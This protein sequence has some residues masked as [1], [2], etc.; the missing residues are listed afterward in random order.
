MRSIPA[1]LAAALTLGACGSASNAAM[2]TSPHPATIARPEPSAVAEARADSARRPYTE[3]DV[4][5]MT[6]MIGHHAQAIV[7]AGW[8]PSHGASPSMRTLA[9]R[10]IN[11]QQDEIA[12]MQ[13]W[14]ARPAASRCPRPHRSMDD[15]ARCTE[16]LMPGMLTEE[17]MQAARPGARGRSSTACS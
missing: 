7:M 12:T 16:M 17:Q 2:R 14:L 15:D 10:I 8:A 4:H 1:A 3:A 5:F 6:A 9:A 11:A 13:R